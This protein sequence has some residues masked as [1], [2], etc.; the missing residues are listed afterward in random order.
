MP[1]KG[2]EKR[3]YTPRKATVAAAPSRGAVGAAGAVG[4]SIGN[5][6]T[7]KESELPVREARELKRLRQHRE[8]L[9]ALLTKQDVEVYRL[10]SQFYH[11]CSHV[12][13]SLFLRGGGVLANGSNAT[14]ADQR[15]R[16]VGIGRRG[17]T[18]TTRNDGAPSAE[19]GEPLLPQHQGIATPGQV[20]VVSDAVSLLAP[21]GNE[22]AVNASAGFASML[23]SDSSRAYH[24]RLH[25]FSPAERFFS[26]SSIGA[27][28]R[29]EGYLSREKAAGR[30][31]SLHEVSSLTPFEDPIFRQEAKAS[32]VGAAAGSG[33]RSNIDERT[34]K[35]RYRRRKF[36]EEAVG[37]EPTVVDSAARGLKR[38]RSSLDGEMM[39]TRRG[40]GM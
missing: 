19:G 11:L 27:L 25:S 33:S 12:G 39:P 4:V 20:P 23:S 14:R 40:R 30:A 24:A 3:R 37:T 26:F 21:H 8:E 28:A 1:P 2:Y 32:E 34:G 5:G 36:G 7:L 6:L 10:E 31:A 16:T 29:V 13:G 17:G 35:R 9:E 15:R 38:G 18:S 22:F